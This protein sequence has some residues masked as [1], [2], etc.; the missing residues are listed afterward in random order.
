MLLTMSVKLLWLQEQK[1]AGNLDGT[2]SENRLSSF[3]GDLLRHIFERVVWGDGNRAGQPTP[4]ATIARRTKNW[5]RKH[6]S[7]G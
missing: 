1:A 7:I 3:R 4:A 2:F 6:C 5:M